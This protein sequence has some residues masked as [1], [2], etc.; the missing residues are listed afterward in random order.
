MFSLLTPAGLSERPVAER[1]RL[2]F[3]LGHLEAFDWNLMCR[4]ALGRPSIDATL[5]KLFAFGIDPVDGNVP[6]DSLHDW[7][8]SDQLRPWIAKVRAEVDAAIASGPFTGWLEDGWAAHLAIE[9]RL[10][11]AETLCYLLRRLDVRFKVSGVL[12]RVS[13]GRHD[14]ALMEVPAGEAVLGLERAVSPF[15]GWDN[16]YERHQQHVPAFRI[17]RFPVTAGQ[18]LAF[19][20]AGGYRER[21][22]WAADDWAWRTREDVTHPAA[23]TFHDGQW[24]WT[25]MFGEVPLPLD[26]PVCVSHAEASAYA[27]FHDARLPTEGQ[28]HRAS[29][30]AR[31]LRSTGHGFEPSAIGSDPEADSAW[32]VSELIGNGWEWTSTVFTPFADFQ[33]LPFY[34]G[35]SGDFFDGR[36]RVLKGASVRTDETFFRPSF[37]NWFQ[38]HYAHPFTKF[39]LVTHG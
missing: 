36:H 24:W 1:H 27:R 7:P 5:E 30:G 17:A 25:A 9:H 32:G 6:G 4:D 12:P 16:E 3:Y 11:H 13:A 23:W 34:R 21:S 15:L 2:I 19:L 18:Y 8:S 37:R 10:M 20:E 29:T 26:W 14:D 39:R 38:P 28:W 35:Y 33:A 31:A 22:L